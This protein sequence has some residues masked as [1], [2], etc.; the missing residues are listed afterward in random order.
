MLVKHQTWVVMLFLPHFGF[1]VF[2]TMYK[3]YYIITTCPLC[4][5][6]Y[7]INSKF[8]KKI[9]IIWKVIVR[10]PNFHLHKNNYSELR[11]SPNPSKSRCN[12]VDWEMSTGFEVPFSTIPVGV[13]SEGMS[14]SRESNK[15]SLCP[16]LILNSQTLFRVGH[17][18]P[19]SAHAFLQESASWDFKKGHFLLC[20][21]VKNYL[22]QKLKTNGVHDCFHQG[23]LFFPS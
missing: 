11:H 14:D 8:T 21:K 1:V 5:Q 20:F 2:L 13:E 18:Y 10:V 6:V 23:F 4:E 12:T 3:R 17:G 9:I 16:V 7:F 22:F 15:T 19:I